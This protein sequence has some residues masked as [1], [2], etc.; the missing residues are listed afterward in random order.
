MTEDLNQLKL[1]LVKKKE[2]QQMAGRTVGSKPNDCFKMV[3]QYHTARFSN[4][5]TYFR[6]V[7]SQCGRNYKLQVERS[8]HGKLK[9]Q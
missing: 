6:V 8:N 1:V 5:E 2:D 9:I 7:G 3:Y 4:P